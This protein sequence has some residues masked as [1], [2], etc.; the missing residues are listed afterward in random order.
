[1]TTLRR[2]SSLDST[3][4]G[5]ESGFT[6][7]IAIGVMFVTSLLLAAAFTAANGDIKLT[8][9]ESIQKQAY[10]AALAGIQEYEYKMQANPDYWETC[11]SPSN[12]VPQEPGERYEIKLLVASTAKGLTECSTSKPFESM[13]ESSGSVANTF[14]IQSTGYAGT[15][16]HTIV[17]TFKVIGFLNY[18]YYT[19][20]ETEDPGLYGG[21]KGCEVY[22][23]ERESWDKSHSSE[24]CQEI[25]FIGENGT[26][27]EVKGPMHT[28]DAADICGTP[29]FGRAGH[30]PADVV[31]MNRGTYAG[32]SGCSNKATYNTAT[33][34]YTKGVELVPP[35]SDESLSQ[36][37]EPENEFTG[38]T[39]LTLNGSTITVE[40]AGVP[41]GKETIEW[42]KNGLI[43]VK[44]N[45][46]GKESCEYNYNPLKSD[47]S[48]EQSE[49]VNCGNVYVS[50]Q[51]TSALTIGAADDVIIN[52]NISPTSVTT[53]GEVPT[54]TSTLG[55]IANNYV[56][57]YHPVAEVSK[58][59]TNATGSLKNPWIYAAILSTNH[60]FVVDNYNCGA[61]LE[62]LNVYGAI[63][64]DFRG[65][66]G[67]GGNTGYIKNYNYDERL[68]VDEPPYFLSPLNAGWKV[69][70][71]TAPTGG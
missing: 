62:K 9:H 70:R 19:N 41:G 29:I 37:V 3:S 43:W 63:A 18:V 23:K 2:R 54:G 34:S 10:Y 52:G 28:N 61:L 38:V 6:M 47:E 16:S 67:T 51:Y 8:Y 42:P 48:E 32:E 17:A 15:V 36:Y 60:S 45:S 27:D 58:K 69:A 24:E 31:E 64:Q 20:F 65:I 4:L 50:G 68:A 66:V 56:R 22:R 13:I 11:V 57:V 33:K 49:E 53:L 44:A 46:S 21:A 30:L 71:E 39:H 59:C 14:R 26:N 55:L 25:Q 1:M 7:I 12:T 35:T 5:S 40:N